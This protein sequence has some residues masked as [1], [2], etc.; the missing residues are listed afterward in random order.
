ALIALSVLVPTSAL[1]DPPARLVEQITDTAAALGSGG[2]GTDAAAS[3]TAGGLPWPWVAA[4]AVLAGLGAGAFVLARRRP[5]PGAGSRSD[6]TRTSIPV[7]DPAPRE[8]SLEDVRT[9]CAT[10]L[11][12]ADDSIKTSEQEL[13]FAIAQ[14]GAEPAALFT[15]ALAESK[16]EVARAFALAH[17]AKQQGGTPAEIATLE[18]IT[19]LCRSAEDR[20]D[21]QVADFDEL[22]DLDSHIDQTLPAL[23][24]QVSSLRTD[25]ASAAQ[26]VQ[27]LQA[28]NAPEL[29]ATI[30]A[31]LEEARQRVDFAA[32]SVRMGIGLLTESDRNGAVACARAAEEAIA[33]A[34]TLVAAVQRAPADLESAREAVAGLIIETEKDIAEAR[35]F[36]ASA[37]L[38][39]PVRYAAETL[40]SARASVESGNYD[41]MV[42]RQ[43]L[44]ES[45]GAL[46]K[47]L[48]PARDAA[49]MRTRAQTLLASQ[50][51]AA[52]ASIQAADDFIRTRRGGIGA[53]AR[54][55]LA[56]AQREFESPAAVGDDPASALTAMQSADRLADE[57]LALAQGDEAGF[58]TT[59]QRGGGLDVGDLVLGGIVVSSMLRRGHGPSGGGTRGGGAAGSRGPGSFGGGR[60]RARRS[61]DGRF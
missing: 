60:T 8:A 38:A 49:V 34:R 50:T 11:I 24:T 22:R 30:G 37:D 47:A 43:A 17:E 31:N 18:Q 51:E 3:T 44:A 58:R 15:A 27:G 7:A 26:I 55:R 21:E 4:I 29:L 23:G 33:Q 25:L 39:G 12:E 9:A 28:A 14:F 2:T 45:D 36:E 53:E 56:A 16:M 1:A 61:G 19:A 59:Q 13:G 46:E 20:L 35:T 57:A 5:G 54:T 42:V 40:A 52:R 32:E 10:A 6:P 41:P 48:G